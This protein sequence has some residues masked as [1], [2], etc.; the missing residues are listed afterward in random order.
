MSFSPLWPFLEKS[1]IVAVLQRNTH[2]CACR[3]KNLRHTKNGLLTDVVQSH[4]LTRVDLSSQTLY[5]VQRRVEPAT[6][7]LPEFRFGMSI[8]RRSSNEIF[9]AQNLNR[10]HRHLTFQMSY[11]RRTT[12]NVS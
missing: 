7:P 8:P 1:L 10:R 5:L 2:L 9:P 3:L 12:S 4:K 11:R 6:K